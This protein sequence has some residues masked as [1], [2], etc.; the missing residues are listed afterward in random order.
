MYNR[1]LKIIFLIS[2]LA[3]SGYSAADNAL[4]ARAYTC[5]DLQQ[6]IYEQEKVVLKGIFGARNSVFASAESCGRYKRPIWTA[7]TTKDVFSCP[8]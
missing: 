8:V 7:W 6:L 3:L 1:T 2:A 5:H 4:N